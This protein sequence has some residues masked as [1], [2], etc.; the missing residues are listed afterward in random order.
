MKYG[1]HDML[2]RYLYDI[3]VNATTTA[4]ELKRAFAAWWITAAQAAKI[5]CLYNRLS[6]YAG[7][8]ER[9]SCAVAFSVEALGPLDD[10]VRQA[11]FTRRLA[12]RAHGAA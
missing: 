6:E 9:I 2:R 12:H 1:F 3:K 10:K 11:L 5:L 7:G 8:I 4:D